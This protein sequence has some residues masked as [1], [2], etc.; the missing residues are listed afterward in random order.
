[1]AL[2]HRWPMLENA[3]DVVGGLNMTN[4]G[5]VTFSSDGAL[6]DSASKNLAFTRSAFRPSSISIWI[7]GTLVNRLFGAAASGD[8]GYSLFYSSSKL[9]FVPI[10]SE[11]AVA[12]SQSSPIENW[13][14]VVGV[15]DT[16]TIALFRDNTKEATATMSGVTS[17]TDFG[18]NAYTPTAGPLNILDV[19]WFD[20]ALDDSEVAAIYAAGPNGE[21]ATI[22]R[23]SAPT[24]VIL[25]TMPAA[26]TRG[27][28]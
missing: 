22:L 20:H 1:M 7:K 2:I 13:M 27:F 16:N 28:R 5:G 17:R 4:N 9:W 11:T 15:A 3:N 14:H 19:C 21:I 26:L 18:I 23:R 8:N 25:S 10:H 12:V 24:P 6:I